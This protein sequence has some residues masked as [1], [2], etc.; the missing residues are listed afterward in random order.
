MLVVVS[1]PLINGRFRIEGDIPDSVLGFVEKEFGKENISIKND[2]GDEL[3]DPFELD[4]FKDFN[5]R[6]TPGGNLRFYRKLVGMTQAE[7][8]ERLGTS[9]QAISGME[10]GRRS[11]SKATAKELSRIFDVSVARFI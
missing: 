4:F 2:D 3:I 11:I 9:K 6:E 10:N 7:L 5:K 1:Q 8:A